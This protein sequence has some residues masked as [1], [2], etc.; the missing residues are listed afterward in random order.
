[1]TVNMLHS[2]NFQSYH[3]SRFDIAVIA[4]R[5]LHWRAVDFDLTIGTS[6]FDASEGSCQPGRYPVHR[7]RPTRRN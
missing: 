5:L 1:M 7:A 2:S 3:K 4:N 6:N